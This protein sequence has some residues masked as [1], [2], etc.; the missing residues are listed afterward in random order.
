MSLTRGLP[1]IL[2]VSGGLGLLAAVALMVERV[3]V[4][5]DPT[6]VP[7]CSIN[8]VLSCGSVMTS[9][10]AS[11]FGIPNAIIGI[12]GFAMVL[13][14]GVALLAGATFRRWFWWGL[15]AG[16]TFA[17]AFVFW[18]I[19]QTL[20]RIEALCPY[21]LVVWAVVVPLFWYVFLYNIEESSRNDTR[22][23]SRLALI[24]TQYHSAFLCLWYLILVLLIAWVFWL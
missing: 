2:A 3:W 23:E 16:T 21:C 1:W 7:I 10:Q 13:T 4:L 18:L 24:L 17:L 6:R 8:A 11:A 9:P 19:Y 12:A 22:H 15:Q 5:E 14:I 20:F